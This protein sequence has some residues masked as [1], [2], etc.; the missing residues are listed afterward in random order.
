MHFK[1]YS[2]AALT[3]PASITIAV[4][5]GQIV[6]LPTGVL[7]YDRKKTSMNA[8]N[9]TFTDASNLQ[10]HAYME[11]H[12]KNKGT[13]NFVCMIIVLVAERKEILRY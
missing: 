7:V 11:C 4:L 13:N 9:L 2:N 10:S 5:K 8:V 3:G 1:N 6:Y 12:Q